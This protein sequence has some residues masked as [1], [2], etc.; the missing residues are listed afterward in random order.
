MQQQGGKGLFS[1]TEATPM[2]TFENRHE[3]IRSGQTQQ[4]VV[5][6]LG[7]PLVTRHLEKQPGFGPIPTNLNQGD[8]YEQ[9]QY[10]VEGTVYIVWFAA[11]PEHRSDIWTVIG[12]TTFEEGIIF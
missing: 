11:T 6:R 4:E 3:S 8:R 5:K 10:S 2:P 7:F 1:V 12:K 9:W